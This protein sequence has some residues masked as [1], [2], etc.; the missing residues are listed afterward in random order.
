MPVLTKTKNGKSKNNGFEIL[1]KME[2][3]FRLKSDIFCGFSENSLNFIEKA[4][5][6]NGVENVTINPEINNALVC[7]NSEEVE[8][9]LI[10]K[11][12]FSKNG[13]YLKNGNGIVVT[14]IFSNP[15]VKQELDKYKIEFNRY[16]DLVAPWEIKHTLPGRIRISH[17]LF[18][19]NKDYI[20]KLGDNLLDTPGIEKVKG[21][22]LSYNVLIIYNEDKFTR[23]KLIRILEDNLLDLI[24]KGDSLVKSENR[25]SRAL[26]SMGFAAL[27]QFSM[28]WAAPLAFLAVVLTGIPIFKSAIE[29]L[30]EKKIKVDMLDAIVILSCLVTSQVFAAAFMVWIV[31]FAGDMLDKTTEQSKRFLSQVFGKQPRFAW[32][33]KDG[34]EIQVSVNKLKKGDIIT[35]SAGEAI[36]IDGKIHSGEAMVDQQSLTG[37]SAPAEKMTKDKVY[38]CTS[39]IAGKIYVEVEE[40]GENTMSAKIVKIIN[41]SANYKGKVHSMGEKIADKMVLPTLGLAALGMATAGHGAALAI[42]NSDYGTGIRVAAPMALLAYLA[43][44][45][46]HGIL[47]KKGSALELLNEIDAVLFDKTGTL[48]HETPEVGD[49]VCA[50]KKYTPDQIL[51]YAASAE[52]RFAHP[53]AKAILQ[54]AEELKLKLPRRDDSKYQVGF[55]IQVV[56]EDR[57]VKVG[58]FRY[59]QKENIPLNKII[60]DKFKEIEAKGRG[61]IFVAIDDV[62]AGMLELKSCKRPEAFDIIQNL[63]KRGVKDIILISGDRKGPTQEIAQRLGIERFYAEVLPQDKANY[64]KMLQ[65]EGKKVAMVGDGINDSVALSLA[66]VSISLR[67]ASDIATDVADVIFMDGDL[68]KFDLLFEISDKFKRNVKRSFSMIAIPNTLCIIGALFGA[69]GLEASIIF[70]NMFNFAATMNGLLPLYKSYPEEKENDGKLKDERENTGKDHEKIAA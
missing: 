32:L 6:V 28:P 7:F 64:V 56:I 31:D 29:A 66:D 68:A 55:G 69:F 25:V 5:S 18:Y 11:H 17:P 9:K 48:T 43:R 52:Q 23:N 26:I 19:K 30:K 16:D 67:G 20:Q 10:L 3:R 35:V 65:S 37:E 63:K 1:Y 59:M 24:G 50:G 27:V 51:A 8:D 4:F 60:L 21:D 39:V 57:L 45:A 40:A 54:K 38:A 47:V 34:Q 61:A 49:I 41:E 58:S 33:V 53:I 13:K 14:S 62:A 70:N 44:A 46:K 15:Q 22:N 36:P 2:N 42:V 12:V